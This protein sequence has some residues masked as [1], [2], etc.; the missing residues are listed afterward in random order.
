MLEEQLSAT[1]TPDEVTAVCLG[2]Y[3]EAAATDPRMLHTFDLLGA[4][5][6]TE[7]VP[8][9][10]INRHLS[11]PFYSLPPEPP[12]PP[13]SVQE[14]PSFFSQ[15]KQLLSF[16]NKTPTPALPS[17]TGGY[18]MLR[19]LRDCPLIAFK[20]YSKGEFEYLQV[21]S[22]AA[23]DLSQVFLK[24]TVPKLEQTHLAEAEE[25]F[26]RTAWF[27]QYRKFDAE[28]SLSLYHSSL[29]G[30]A[31]PGVLTHEQFLSSSHAEAGHLQYSQYL[32]LL[33]H[34]HR[35]LSSIIAQLKAVDDDFPSTQFCQ[36]SRHH[37]THL[38]Q[39][40]TLSLADHA[41]C[42]Y[43]RALVASVTS[44]DTASTLAL[45]RSVLEEQRSVLGPQC[46]AVAR[47][48]TDMADLLFSLEDITGA[49]D[50]LES[51]L[52]MYQNTPPQ[53]REPDHDLELG[54]TMSSLAVVASTLGEKVRS[55]DLLE[56]AL[57]LYQSVPA[58]ETVSLHQRRLVAN[59]LT[60]LAHAYLTLGNLIMAQK[61]IELSV[62]A[63][64]TIYPEGSQETVR[65]FSVAS[66]V[67][68]LLGDQRESQRV[69]D[70]A[71]K[72]QKKIEKQQLVFM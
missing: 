37:L 24:R 56:S 20:K 39:C 55:R 67:Y 4:L 36:Y 9:S 57:S 31:S 72:V 22:T 42:S 11:S 3:L 48:L 21:H 16:G 26:H 10:L 30:V 33:S 27:K 71:G 5:D 53:A 45:Y 17:L 54:L 1:S 66:L 8:A 38:L 69:R 35:V 46:P 50:L 63:Q 43:G 15:L 41:R 32:H 65:A 60:D 29:P 13:E 40:E 14:E 61:Y 28:K 68:S 19:F 34:R 2:L 64:P 59:T 52:Q 12:T 25:K 70:E 62:L 47:T 18:D 44:H 6:P 49:R 23:R 7:P 51:A 58:G